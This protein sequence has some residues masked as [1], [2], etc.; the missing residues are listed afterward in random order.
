M[1]EIVEKKEKEVEGYGISRYFLLTVLLSF[2]GWAYETLFMFWQFKVLQNSGFMTLPICPIYGCSLM[3]VYLLVGT[4]DEGRG[5]L[6]KTD[7][8][9]TRYIL[10]G[11][12]AFVIPTVAELIVGAFFHRA[13]GVRFW[14]YAGAPMNW[15]GY[16]CLPVSLAWAGMIFLFMKYVF[17]LLKKTL[18]KIPKLAAN[19]LAFSLLFILLVDISLNFAKLLY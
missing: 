8:K 12:F 13:F 14:S 17:P 11:V 1:G 16:V 2:L 19:G 15:N 4:P 7:N 5:F 6:R 3:A 9:T 10:Y 18:E